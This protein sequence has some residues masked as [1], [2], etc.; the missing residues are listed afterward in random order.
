MS[1]TQITIERVNEVKPHPN[2]DRLDVIQI[3]GYTVITGKGNFQVGD[4]AIYFPPDILLPGNV[5][6]QFEVTKYLKHAIY[7]GHLVKSQ[8]RVAACRLRGLPSHGFASPY[9]GSDPYGTDVTEHYGGMK[10]VPPVR[11]NAGDA[12]PDLVTFH[13][14]TSIENVQRFPELIETGTT[15][16]YTEKIHGTN[17]RVGIVRNGEGLWQFVAGSHNVVRKHP[18]MYWDPMTLQVIDVLLDLCQAKHDVVIFGEIFGEGV[19]DLDY[20]RQRTFRVFDVTIDGIYQDWDT[21]VSL[22]LPTVPVLEV[23]P[24]SLDKVEELTYGKT[25]LANPDQIKSKF[26]DREGVVVTPVMEDI[27]RVG[28]RRIVKSVSADYRDRKG[29]KDIE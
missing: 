9:K 25:T 18:S 20:G 19:Q 8:C 16:R 24:F 14:Y 17:C 26:K 1:T 5:A 3:L 27:D 15:V 22:G 6:D 23:G 2:A 21:V 28:R 11:A 29:A 12:A 4:S 7:P 13:K 10:Y